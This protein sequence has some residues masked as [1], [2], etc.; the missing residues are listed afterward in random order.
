[1]AGLVAAMT[2]G[3]SV[4][5]RAVAQAPSMN[6]SSSRSAYLASPMGT[7][8]HNTRSVRHRQS[9]RSRVHISAAVVDRP[10]T[11]QAAQNPPPQRGSSP[12]NG[13]WASSSISGQES[14]SDVPRKLRVG[15]ITADMKR[16]R[17]QMEEDEQLSSLMAGLRGQN[18]R[19]EQFADANVQ[20]RLVE[21]GSGKAG[22]EDA[23]PLVYDP[24][25]IAAYWGKRPGAV[26][27]RIAQ[28]LKVSGSFLF[29]LA[30]DAIAGRL[31]E[32][33]VQRAAELREIVTSLGPAYIKLGQA[34]SIRPDVLSPA[35]MVELQKL[36][37]KVPSFDSEIAMKLIEEELGMKPEEV[38]S[39]LTPAPIAAASLGQVYK[40]KL[41]S[42]GHQVAVK[43]QRPFVLETVTIDLFIIRRLGLY[44]KKIPQLASRIDVVGLVDEWAARFFEELDYVNEG[45]NA[46]LFA[47]SMAKD[48]PQVREG[49]TWRGE[50]GG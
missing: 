35:A 18:L 20:M 24:D 43:V 10:R 16:I 44:V 9:Q 38:F 8:A 30:R 7:V 37:D 50:E 17:A 31:S 40:G 3:M 1:M 21:V 47:A 14:F 5:S 23:L 19:D 26:T 39:E 49:D 6:L 48:L 2:E 11:S 22:E 32:T 36:C 27:Q 34:L 13:T 41:R 33:E 45:R 42:N 46:T 4:T 12:S 25:L 29:N 15:D 28:L